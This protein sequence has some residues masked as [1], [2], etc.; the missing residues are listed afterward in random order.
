MKN[1]VLVLLS[2]IC[3]SFG[4]YQVHRSYYIVENFCS[5]KYQYNVESYKSCKRL[6]PNKLIKQLTKDEQNK[7]IDK[8]P[9]IPLL[10]IK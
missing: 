8:I 9:T 2:I 4:I 5:I 7:Y 6:T 3:V 10:P 1:I